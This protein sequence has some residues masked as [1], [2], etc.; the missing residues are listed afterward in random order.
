M[1]D[2]LLQDCRMYP[3]LRLMISSSGMKQPMY[4]G[5]AFDWHGKIPVVQYTVD[6]WP[7][8][9]LGLSLVESVGSIERTKRKHERK[10]DQVISTRLNPPMGYDRTSVGG[11]KIEQFDLF[12]QNVRAGMDG[13]PKEVLQSLLPEEV[14]V[15]EVNFAFLDRL[16]H[17]EEQQ[18]GINDLGNIENMKLNVSS[19]GFDKALESIGPIAKGIASSMEAANA[20]VAYLL[21]FL[22]PQYMDTRRIIEYIGPDHITPEMYD[23]DPDSIVPSHMPDEMVNI[24]GTLMF[25]HDTIEGIIIPR[26]SMYDKL[27]RARNFAK[28]L[29]LISIPSTLLKITQL[30]E[31]LKYLQL[32]RGGFPISPHTVAKKLGIENY[33]D[34]PGDTE[35]EKYVNWEKLK[36]ALIAE[37]QQLGTELGIQNPADGQGGAHPE[38]RPP[39]GQTAPRLVQKP[40]NTD[41]N[42]RTTV[43]ESR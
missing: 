6:D 18:L 40:G 33:G 17:M 41:G 29:R 9:S 14:S 35:F 11:P 24:G 30:Q 22:I 8:E 39:S 20:K 26:A 21:K 23:Y 3:N 36:L 37:A 10:M 16:S 27:A 42:P 13:K 15:S 28:N 12:E 1:R 31:Q 5:P 4:D 38:G 25:P 7:W 43:V 34:I 2:A 32:Y 19:D